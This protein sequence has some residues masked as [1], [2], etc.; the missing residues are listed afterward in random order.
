MPPFFN[1]IET[2][3]TSLERVKWASQ[4]G[5]TAKLRIANARIYRAIDKLMREPWHKPQMLIMTAFTETADVLDLPS[6][7]HLMDF[8]LSSVRF[9]LKS[10]TGVEELMAVGIPP[11]RIQKQPRLALSD[12]GTPP[13][14]QKAAI[15]FNGAIEIESS[16]EKVTTSRANVSH[17]AP[18]A[19]F[20]A[21]PPLLPVA[22]RRTDRHHVTAGRA[23]QSAPCPSR[24]MA[25][26]HRQGSAARATCLSPR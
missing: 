11:M 25:V 8:E 18:A 16:L 19:W 26:P 2:Y 23:S 15:S 13:P 10:E 17:R 12:G 5:A 1:S 9:G 24:T 22:L 6:S 4:L 14:K 7:R 20:L 21:P 3:L